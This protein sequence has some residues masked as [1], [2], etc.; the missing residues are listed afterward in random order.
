MIRIPALTEKTQKRMLL[1]PALIVL[2]AFTTLPYIM[3]FVLGLFKYDAAN[4]GANR[5]IGL[6]NYIDAMKDA[7]FWNSL[8]VTVL[9]VTT[10]VAIEVVLGIAIAVLF[11]G[12]PKGRGLFQSLLLVPM[13]VPP[14]VV[15]LNWKLLLDPNYGIINYFF[16]LLGIPQQVW[17]SDPTWAIFALAIVDVWQ[18]TP[19]IALLTLAI[20]VALPRDPYEAAYLDGA[21]PAQMFRFITLPLMRQGLTIIIM[22][23]VIECF[24]DFA[25]VYT[26][27]SGGPGI[28]TETLN[29]YV[30]I[31]GFEF[32]KLGYSSA[33]AIILFAIILVVSIFLMRKTTAQEKMQ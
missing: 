8:R 31:N 22:L 17:L 23:R 13:V 14:I 26:L 24:K 32:Y 29:F 10:S 7:R 28:A 9:F 20:L 2:A 12:L 30:Y 25:K 3:T 4:L 27:T 19:F 16:S 6:N 18:Y 1:I 33:L 5:F 11:N 21:N 15:G